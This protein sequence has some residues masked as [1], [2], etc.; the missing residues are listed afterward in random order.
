MIAQGLLSLQMPSS[1]DGQPTE[2]SQVDALRDSH[3]CGDSIRIE[4]FKDTAG[5]E[6]FLSMVKKVEKE[7][8]KRR[9]A[10]SGGWPLAP[11]I[12]NEY[13]SLAFFSAT[14]S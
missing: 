5:E 6:E 9:A 3:S 12:S 4:L 1:D 10:A 14:I 2:T 8:E 13:F 11:Q 7:E